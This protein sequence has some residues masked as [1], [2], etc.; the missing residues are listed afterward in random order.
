VRGEKDDLSKTRITDVHTP[1]GC[2]VHVHVSLPSRP[3]E[4]PPVPWRH[5]VEGIHTPIFSK[6]QTLR[7]TNSPHACPGGEVISSAPIQTAQSE[8]L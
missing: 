2:F 6:N 5:T 1:D 8:Q 7:V 3:D 4:R